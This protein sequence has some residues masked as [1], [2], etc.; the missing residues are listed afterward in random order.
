MKR[1]VLD[2]ETDDL[3]ATVVHCIVAQ[4]LDTGAVDT[5]YG[6]SIKDFPAWSESVDVFV[7][8]NGV[9][10]DAP[11]VNRLTGSKIPL[12]KVRDTLIM[13][14][15]YDPSLEGGHSLDA[16]GQR[17]G[18]PKIEFNDFSVF[19]QQMLDY[20]KQDVV[21]TVKLYEHL[22]PHMEKY[23]GKSIQLEH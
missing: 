9:S 11:V 3:N 15:L 19:T 5:W 10:F 21:V 17:L 2:I 8:H 6:E 4:D 13:S 1:V 16:W 14:Q 18:Y 20:C 7:M 22:L 12:K 23:S